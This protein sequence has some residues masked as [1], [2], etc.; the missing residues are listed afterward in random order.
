MIVKDNL[1]YV[2]VRK[3]TQDTSLID[4]VGEIKVDMEF[5]FNNTITPMVVEIDC[6]IMKKVLDGV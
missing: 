6:L 3:L 1:M 2:K 4:E 5:C